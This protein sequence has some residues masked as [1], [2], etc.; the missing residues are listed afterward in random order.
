MERR[1]REEEEEEVSLEE[2]L[3]KQK[4]SDLNLALETTFGGDKVSSELNDLD[5]PNTKEEF[6]NFTDLLSKKLTPL[7]KNAEYPTFIENLT[8][9][10]C[11]T[12]KF[13]L[14]KIFICDVMYR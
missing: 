6:E 1:I 5:M 10:L 3:R 7:S 13:V 9:N 14:M 12:S 11:A 2:R 8:R 4:E